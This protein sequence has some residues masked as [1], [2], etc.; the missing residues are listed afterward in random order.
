MVL[1]ERVCD[2]ASR[3]CVFAVLAMCAVV[4]CPVFVVLCVVVPRLFCVWL[5]AVWL[6][7]KLWLCWLGM[8]VRVVVG[9][10]GV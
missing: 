5:W 8:C 9:A 2:C 7:V 4:W 6:L 1:I 10:C 3:A